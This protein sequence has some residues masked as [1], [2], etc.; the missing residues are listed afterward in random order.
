MRTTRSYPNGQT[1]VSVVMQCDAGCLNVRGL[2]VN[3][4]TI[5]PSLPYICSLISFATVGLY[6][7]WINVK[8]TE[9]WKIVNNAFIKCVFCRS[10]PLHPCLYFLSESCSR[11]FLVRSFRLYRLLCK[12]RRVIS[13]HWPHIIGF[14]GRVLQLSVI[15]NVHK[16][17]TGEIRNRIIAVP[18]NSDFMCEIISLNFWHN[19][20]VT[21]LD[22]CMK[23]KFRL[24]ALTD[25][26]RALL[27]LHPHLQVSSS[28]KV[29]QLSYFHP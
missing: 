25:L 11:M 7:R 13:W 17:V 9:V 3:V 29:H 28:S 24:T 15:K 19:L 1:E 2:S 27:G 6:L 16:H 23:I 10:E 18:L 12:W 22:S 21:K 20:L 5:N 8:A 26:P 4:R 14:W